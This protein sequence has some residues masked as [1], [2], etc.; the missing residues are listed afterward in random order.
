MSAALIKFTRWLTRHPVIALLLLA[1]A[2]ILAGV[3]ATTQFRVNADQ[4]SLVAPDAPF[5]LRYAA[6]RDA[7]PAYKRTS[8]VVVE[9]A[10]RPAAIAAAQDLALE[11]EKRTDIFQSV[12]ASAALP[13]FQRNGLLYLSTEELEARLDSIVQAQ[14]GIA[15]ILRQKGVAGLLTLIDEGTLDTTAKQQTGTADVPASLLDLA[16]TLTQ[17]ADH[18]AAGTDRQLRIA[19]PGLTPA[20]GDTAIELISV[21]IREDQSDMTSP[22]AK[23]EVIREAAKSIGL[24]EEN[25]IRI[26]L[27]GNVPLSVDELQQVRQSLGLAGALSFIML[28]LVLGLGVRSG[29]IVAVMFITLLVGAVWSMAWAMASVGE[30]NIL[31][32]SF[33]VLFVGLGIDF[34]IHY[35][36]RAQE[37]V[38]N[39]MSTPKALTEAAGEVGPAIMLGA[40]TSA[41][42]FLSFMPTD[43]KGFA[44]L[45]V[46]AGG[47]MI[48]ACLA[49]MTVI[50]ASLALMGIPDQR[51]AGARFN[52][53]TG[54]LFT[55]SR[56]L[57]G[58]VALAAGMIGLA[59]AAISTRTS[60]DF[61]TLALKNGKSEPIQALADLQNRGLATDYA[62]YI[63]TTSQDDAETAAARLKN[64]AT[65]K[66]VRTA[67]DLI[68][69]NQQDKLDLIGETGFL[70]FGLRNSLE[71]PAADVPPDPQVSVP[72]T[73]TPAAATTL[74]DLNTALSALSPSQMETLNI[75]LADQ[76]T[77]DLSILMA[78]FD[79]EPVTTLEQVPQGM[80]ERFLAEDGRKLV[81]GLP[82]GDLTRTPELRRFVTEV[83]NAF[84]EST[85]RAVVEA[86]V[87]DVVV[88]AFVTALMLA[89]AAVATVVFLTTRSI[90]DTAL[91]LTPL[92]LAALATTATGVV[93]GMPF[94]Q[95][96]II[97]LPLIMGLGVDNGI[98][99]LMRYRRDGSLDGLL[100]SSTPRA[101]VLSTLTTIGAFG[102]LSA[103]VHAG[104]A[105]MGVLL[106]IAMLYLLVATVL[107]LPALL[108]LRAKLQAR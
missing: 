102:A 6:F 37:D 49:A 16:A 83:K 51:G 54:H 77:R 8:L 21:R 105:S 12:F 94:N 76:L 43:Y 101:I 88:N 64:L 72:D 100:A 32:A 1:F 60:F 103:S 45:G 59:A 61:S 7:F 27:T 50:P 5:Q 48:L 95:A 3:Y 40:C 87:G 23:L 80:R 99:V 93:I 97:V 15:I 91:V 30:V 55:F 33:A 65:V 13:F 73:L 4:T 70:F 41:I 44:D 75:L 63:V 25:G 90:V 14:P 92:L 36:L 46:I 38:E 11:L 86:T 47:G 53:A 96:N 58:R 9:A 106:T 68:P 2:T 78:A 104:T 42:G 69:S 39:G 85:G 22:R 19:L 56:Y 35:A 107:V 57:P 108:S 29:R 20:G 79:A 71:G 74:S 82:T 26:R 81:I 89:L 34:A 18:V 67:A 66:D 62:A 84:P 31:S 10:T 52:K 98:H 28:A 17:L 24:T